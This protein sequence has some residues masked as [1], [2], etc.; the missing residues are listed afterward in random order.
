MPVDRILW[1][2]PF[3][4]LPHWLCPT[5]GVGRL[6]EID[7]SVRVEETGQ[8][9]RDKD[10]DDWDPDWVQERF[11]GFIICDNED[12]GEVC[13]ISGTSGVSY[14]VE[15]DING[16][17]YEVPTNTLV[18]KHI[19]PAPHLFKVP[20]E[21]PEKIK[22][23]LIDGFG[24]I[25]ADPGGCANKF[26]VAVEALLTERKV[27]AFNKPATG[28]K[29]VKLTLHTR[30]ERYRAKNT[31]AADVL[32]AIKWLGNYGSHDDAGLSV[33][34]VLVA[35]DLLEY[36]LKIIYIKSPTAA[37]TAKLINKNK[38]PIK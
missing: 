5:C 22:T 16:S 4:K 38:G 12:C 28:K 3:R 27:P 11:A 25:W 17:I 13:S 33:E 30:I 1:N 21:C 36:A 31:Q 15:E 26:R 6:K 20:D 8:S 35:A 9:K 7:K 2:A 29:R 23:R 14:Y 18:V 37:E 10:A 19:F 32:E 24:L 34:D